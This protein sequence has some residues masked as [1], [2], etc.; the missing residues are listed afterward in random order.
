MR[1]LRIKL[2][3]AFLAG[4]APV[5]WAGIG[6]SSRAGVWYDDLSLFT[7]VLELVHR[8]SLEPVESRRL[9]HGAVRGMLE[10]LDPHSAFLDSE[11]YEGM[12]IDAPGRLHGLGL[13]ITRRRGGSIEVVAA[14]EGTPAARAGIRARDRIDSICLADPPDDWNQECRSSQSMTLFEALQMLR[15]PKESEVSIQ[16]LHQGSERPQ[17]CTLVRDVAKIRS[18]DGRM[19]EPRYPYLRIRVFEQGT[20]W[21]VR[22]TLEELH[23]EAG[24]SF[25][26][27]ILDLRDNPGGPLEQAVEVADVWLTEGRIVYTEGRVEIEPREFRAHRARTE[28][29]YPVAVLVNDGTAGSSEILAG[30]LK[31]HRRALLVGTRTFGKGSAQT[32]YPLEGEGAIW[33]TTALYHTPSGHRIEGVGI[34]PDIAVRSVLASEAATGGTAP[35]HSARQ[36]DAASDGDEEEPGARSDI[37]LDRALEVLKSRA[38][39]DRVKRSQETTRPRAPAE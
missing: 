13:E 22:R 32:L 38:D 14:I 29:S 26:G 9:I 12:E 16:V 21:R 35:R 31:D 36:R 23:E 2:V 17:R 6:A 30:A 15:G 25:E 3:L 19:L 37:Q 4:V 33:L 28:P 8:D 7:R 11:A 10:E 27:L 5:L 20:V 34:R 24:A 39:F 18:V 1:T